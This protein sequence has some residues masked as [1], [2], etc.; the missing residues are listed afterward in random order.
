MFRSDLPMACEQSPLSPRP[1][2]KWNRVFVIAGTEEL[3]IAHFTRSQFLSAI[4]WP[5]DRRL[6]NP[7]P[8]AGYIKN[9]SSGDE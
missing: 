8:I 1:I 9:F 6:V 4:S 5:C 3:K 7:S 2:P